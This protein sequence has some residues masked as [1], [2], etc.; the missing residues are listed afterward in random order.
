MRA[1]YVEAEWAPKEGYHL[2]DRE[3]ADK[4]SARGSN[5][6]KNI[7]GEVTDRPVPEPKEDEVLLK[8]GAAGVC[9]TD[10]HLL[11][12]D[13][14]GYTRYNGHS[15]YPIIIGHEFSGEVV[16][17]G[18]KVKRLHKGDL[19]S[20]ESMNW[21]GECDACRMGMFNQCKNL[22]EPG[23]TYDGGFAEFVVVREKY[24]YV[25]NDIAEFYDDKLTALE[26]GA[27]IEPTGVAYNGIFVRAGGFRPGSH[28]VVFGAG[29]IGLAAISLVKAA[30]CGKL[31]AF[32]T[33]P[34]RLELA[35][36]CGADYAFNPLEYKNADEQA[37][38]IMEIT[39]G[40]GV[41]IFAE[42]SGAT[43]AN[44]PVMGKS[45][46]IGGKCAQIG[47]AVAQPVIDLY[48][49]QFNAAAIYG[50]NGQSGQGIYSDVIAMMASGR[51]DMRHMVTDRVHLEDIKEGIARAQNQVSGKVLVSTHYDRL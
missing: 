46:A 13:D 1:F 25:L 36:L 2:S 21:C 20:V 30:G 9:G 17:C 19:V 45:L 40:R 12:M 28:A 26:M 34:E 24:C 6:W 18:S 29:P 50:S 27:V 16:S 32:D 37:E 8:V 15:K 10:A 7:K 51:I 48:P 33:T 38:H 35:R 22:E 4:R 47:H 43:K 41:G 14:E 3:K 42:C 23:L 39:K 49:F 11:E 31:I 44:Y 5:I